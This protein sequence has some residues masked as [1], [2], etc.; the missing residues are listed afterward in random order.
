[1][2]NHMEG[3][4]VVTDSQEGF[5]KGKSCLTNLV[6]FSD[7]ETASVDKGRATDII[8]LDFC[9]AFDAVPPHIL[10]SKLERNGFDRWTARWKRNWLDGHAQRVLVNSLMSKW[11]PGTSGIPQGSILGPKLINIFINDTVSGIE[12]T[13]SK[14]ADTT[15]LSDAVDSL[16]GRD[17]I[18]R[19]LNRLE[20]QAP[21]VQTS[22][23]STRPSAGPCT[24]VGAI[25]N[26]T[27]DWG[28]N[29]LRAALQRR[30]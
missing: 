9:N 7:E 20:E 3:R 11:K 29:G 27:T 10:A 22:Q 2:L 16:E 6:A 12:C 8:Y 19:E 23:S 25:P 1:M 30:T 21:A 17:V 24:G 18:Q 26:T 14:S 5:T 15:K 28:L 4:E 13:L